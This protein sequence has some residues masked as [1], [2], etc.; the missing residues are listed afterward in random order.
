MS[1]KR[2]LIRHSSGSWNPAFLGTVEKQ[3]LDSSFRWSDEQKRPA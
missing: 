1:K 3:E 2:A